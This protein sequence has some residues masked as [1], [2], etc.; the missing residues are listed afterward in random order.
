MELGLDSLMAL[1]LRNRLEKALA[2]GTPLSSTLVFD[3]PTISAI[4]RHLETC[5]FPEGVEAVEVPVE[6]RQPL[7]DAIATMSEEQAEALLFRKLQTL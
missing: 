6:A 4:A 5:L 2:L 1:E 3:C 7:A